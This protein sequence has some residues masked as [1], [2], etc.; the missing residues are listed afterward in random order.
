MVKRPL[1]IRRSRVF[2]QPG[3]VGVYHCGTAS[4]PK[5]KILLRRTLPGLK[6]EKALRNADAGSFV[7]LSIHMRPLL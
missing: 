7:M 6:A 3:P 1:K 2:T 4:D 5:Q